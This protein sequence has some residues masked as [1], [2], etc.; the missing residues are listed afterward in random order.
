MSAD[1]CYRHPQRESWT[2]CQRCGRTICPECQ[3]GTPAG[4]RCPDCVRETGGSVQWQ[5]PA[6]SENRRPAPKPRTDRSR[7]SRSGSASSSSAASSPFLQRLGGMLRPGGEAPVATWAV[8]GI[9]VVL[10]LAGFLTGHLP[11]A[12]LAADPSVG[13]Q[14]WRYLTAAFVY[15]AAPQSILSILLT[16]FFLAIIAP[17]VE[18]T[19]G[20]S[21]FLIVVVTSAVLGNAAMV[22]A[23][24]TGYG[25]TPILFG[26]FGAYLIFAWPHPAARTQVLVVLGFNLLIS[27]AFGARS[28]PGLIGGLI[29]G[30]GVT[31]LLQRYEGANVRTAYAIIAAGAGAFVLFAVIRSIAF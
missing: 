12:L 20:R 10:F 23:G 7:R 25:L 28:L 29:A 17:A 3:I 26:V 11:I 31:Y 21:R 13:L 4:V 9:V 6:S 24:F 15:P 1:V 30:A 19:L 18:A 5:R 16:G 8:L 27:L 22:L 14:I 2:L